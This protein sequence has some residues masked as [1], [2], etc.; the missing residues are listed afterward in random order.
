MT[1]LRVVSLSAELGIGEEYTMAD[2]GQQNAEM[3]MKRE[4][5]RE[6][7]TIEVE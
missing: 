3:K 1:W 2:D 7:A 5:H 6:G 4:K